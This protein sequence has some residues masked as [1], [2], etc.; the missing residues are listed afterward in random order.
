MKHLPSTRS[1]LISNWRFTRGAKPRSSSFDRGYCK[2]YM[3]PPLAIVD[4]DGKKI[5]YVVRDGKAVQTA[6]QTGVTY[7][8]ALEVKQGVKPGDKVVLKP[9]EK[10]RDGAAVSVAAK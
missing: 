1:P 8:E 6:I 10:L 9:S 7:G 5:V 2:W 4:R 3:V